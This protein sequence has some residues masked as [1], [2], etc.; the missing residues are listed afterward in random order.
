MSFD[1]VACLPAPVAGFFAGA[2]GPTG[3]GGATKDVSPSLMP[4]RGGLAC[5]SAAHC[6]APPG[7]AN[8]FSDS[9]GGRAPTGSDR[10][11]NSF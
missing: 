8:D 1:L 5:G 2:S 11:F 4:G 7:A 3:Q 6:D 10:I 9:A